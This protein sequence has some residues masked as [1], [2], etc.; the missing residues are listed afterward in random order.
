MDIRHLD[1]T[2]VKAGIGYKHLKLLEPRR[3]YLMER[4]NALPPTASAV[5]FSAK[6]RFLR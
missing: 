5:G 3:S 4:R 1:G 6:R 2:K